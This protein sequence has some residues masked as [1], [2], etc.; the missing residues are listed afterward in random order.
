MPMFPE[1]WKDDEQVPSNSTAL[2]DTRS[3][4]GGI[5]IGISNFGRMRRSSTRRKLHFA[6]T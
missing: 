6:E 2:S 1:T 4:D 3:V 5:R